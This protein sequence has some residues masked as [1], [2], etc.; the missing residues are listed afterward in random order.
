MSRDLAVEGGGPGGEER[1]GAKVQAGG[2][3]GLILG[4]AAGGRPSDRPGIGH[5]TARP[6][7]L[8]R[9]VSR[10]ALLSLWLSLAC[11][12][13]GWA[14]P[15]RNVWIPSLAG[16]TELTREGGLVAV[17]PLPFC[18]MAISSEGWCSA[19]VA[20][21]SAGNI[22]V[23]RSAQNPGSGSTD[24]T[25]MRSGVGVVAT[26]PLAARVIS[27]HDG[28]LW[29]IETP[30]YLS[31]T[32]TLT[33][34]APGLLTSLATISVVGYY[35]EVLPHPVDGIWV[36]IGTTPNPTSLRLER[37]SASGALLAS[38]NTI[39]AGPTAWTSDAD[40][41]LWMVQGGTTLHRFTHL[42]GSVIAASA[43]VS[44]G[45]NGFSLVT[46]DGRGLV[47][48]G[49]PAAAGMTIGTFG[50]ALQVVGTRT[51]NVP[52]ISL[53]ADPRGVLWS[54]GVVSGGLWIINEATPSPV[55]RLLH[56]TGVTWQYAYIFGDLTG[57]RYALMTSRTGDP[58]GDGV[59]SS[60]EYRLGSD[61]FDPADRPPILGVTPNPLGG[62]D[63][64]YSDFG[65]APLQ[66]LLAASFTSNTGIG[67]GAGGSSPYTP[68]DF[69]ALLALSLSSPNPPFLGF[70]GQLAN[71]LGTARLLLPPGPP[72]GISVSF[73]GVTF[74]ATPLRIVRASE[75]VILTL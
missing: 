27:D 75:A 15:N 6:T 66:Y 70:Q 33:R 35:V 5:G 67:L 40:G 65:S 57:K 44:L 20:R 12:V 50:P 61:P 55:L 58:D 28:N 25:V 45:G 48:V 16:V 9:M 30:P 32:W 31:T 62:L 42:T 17:H 4:L 36:A 18:T 68:L 2:P 3:G 53:E 37:R 54:L 19:A 1:A 46:V 38:L 22:Y 59:T 39:P 8:C 34:R 43:P 13:P 10:P 47:H 24:I 71:G 52:A 73:A 21:D 11:L 26:V 74:D 72:L 41:N 69:D 29:T 64:A 56:P 14:Q 63:L 49:A 7:M 60:R 51:V 23:T